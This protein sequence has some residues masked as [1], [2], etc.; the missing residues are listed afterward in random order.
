MPVRKNEAYWSESLQRWQIKVQVD[1]QRKTFV[2]SKKNSQP[3]NKRGKIEAERK[4]DAW[5]E[6]R[7]SG[8]K[9][10]VEKAFQKYLDSIKAAGSL[11]HYRKC[12]QY[13]RCW[14]LP[15]IG[16][17]KVRSLTKNDLQ[18]VINNAFQKKGLA[19]K[20]LQN[21]R[22]CLV[23]F[24]KYCRDDNITTFYPGTLSIPATAKKSEKTIVDPRDL[25]ILFTS[26]KSTFKGKI[27]EDPYIH[28]YRFAVLTGVRPGE[29]IALRKQ[30]IKGNKVTIM[31]SIN[32]SGKITQGKNKNAR[33]TFKLGELATL[34]LLDQADL[35]EK[36]GIESQYVFP[37]RDGSHL[38]QKQFRFAWKRYCE[39]NGFAKYVT[40]YELRHT[41]VSI[42]D[43]MPEALKKM[44]V[45]HSK[46]MDTEGV[47]GHRKQDDMDRAAI[48]IDTAFMRYL[49]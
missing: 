17:K 8:D 46:S 26:S 14:I 43:E 29:L 22:G 1:G 24:I 12:E 36:L 27:I 4:A 34:V 16:T 44:I 10:K 2:S 31:Q 23:G 38:T 45:G 15:V 42:N 32:D 49:K 41:F 47:Y 39:A 48:Y 37:A 25:K 33:R 28:A 40:P 3:D 20:T 21:I 5:I 13:D 9:I 11:E 30:D 6:D 35:M 19:E 7:T 18:S